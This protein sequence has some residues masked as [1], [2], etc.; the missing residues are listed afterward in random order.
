[1]PD[2]VIVYISNVAIIQ[3]DLDLAGRHEPRYR[4]H[5]RRLNKFRRELSKLEPLNQ[6]MRAGELIPPELTEMRDKF[7]NKWKVKYDV[8]MQHSA[9][10][11]IALTQY[12]QPFRHRL[13]I[14]QLASTD[15]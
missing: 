15:F 12:F 1:M 3:G 14:T 5:M 13:T 9:L 4:S 10:L 7:E 11:G 6:A 8:L 2:D